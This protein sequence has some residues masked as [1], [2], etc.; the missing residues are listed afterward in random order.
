M[1]LSASHS[2]APT[3]RAMTLVVSVVAVVLTLTLGK[4]DA[5]TFCTWTKVLSNGEVH[6]SFLRTSSHRLYHT[7][8][9]ASRTLSSCSFSD[10]R[11]I[12]QKYI[13]LCNEGHRGFSHRP[14]I[15]ASTVVDEQESCT[16]IESLQTTALEELS[17]KR[18]VRSADVGSGFKTKR[19][20]KRGFIVPG[21]LWCGSGNKAPS[22]SDVGV[23]S[24]TDK[25]CREHDQC[26]DTIL[27][28][29]T[30]FGVFNS[31]I[32][33]MSHCDCDNRFHICLKEAQDSI[34]DVVGYT[35]FNLL[36]MHCFELSYKLQ[37]TERNWF[38][39]CKASN[40]ALYAEVHPP[41]SYVVN[42]EDVNTTS[43]NTTTTPIPVHSTQVLLPAPT[44]SAAASCSTQTTLMSTASTST[45]VIPITTLP[46]RSQS[47]PLPD[48]DIAE[49]WCAAYKY[50]DECRNRILPL[51]RKYDFS[52]NE[53]RTMYHCNCTERFFQSMAASIALTE[54]EALMLDHVSEGCFV[55]QNCT[56]EQICKVKRMRTQ[57]SQVPPGSS[58]NVKEQRHLEV[59]RQR[60]RRPSLRRSSSIRSVRLHG[61]CLRTMR[62][63]VHKS[64]RHHTKET[65][66]KKPE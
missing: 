56:A 17:V 2:S 10:N 19:R 23:F 61:L 52:N 28:F 46:S 47:L 44:G 32:F 66:R 24:E 51:Q 41:T 18:S 65:V 6:Y 39:M 12:I 42:S 54:T 37:C 34:S 35:F 29:H 26:Q 5:L 55:L 9:S 16:S 3:A 48:A 21:T 4:T 53:P 64:K 33:T 20:I 43:Y 60:V 15:R 14:D 58:A 27:S 50:L 59:M 11:T 57:P 30:K 7:I 38:G 31:N 49:T 36:K 13:T 63:K 1:V 8:W 22:Y 45:T 25:C 62:R 40:M